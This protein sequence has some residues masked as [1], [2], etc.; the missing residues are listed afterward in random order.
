VL[1]AGFWL[2]LRETPACS[3]EHIKGL[4]GV[5]KQGAAASGT[6]QEPS[7]AASSDSTSGEDGSSTLETQASG[8]SPGSGNRTSS[9][10]GVDE[11]MPTGKGDA[12]GVLVSSGKAKA[13]KVSFFSVF[14]HRLC[15]F[16]DCRQTEFSCSANMACISVYIQLVFTFSLCSLSLNVQSQSW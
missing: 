10:A 15:P 12:A 6:G 14:K 7:P 4:P 3:F 2:Y 9:A 13:K 5:H 16:D 1:Q 8:E 11:T